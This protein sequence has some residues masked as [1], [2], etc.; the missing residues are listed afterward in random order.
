VGGDG[1]YTGTRSAGSVGWVNK[2][3]ER[4]LSEQAAWVGWTQMQ[5]VGRDSSQ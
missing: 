3:R 5:R 2:C 1:I 4:A